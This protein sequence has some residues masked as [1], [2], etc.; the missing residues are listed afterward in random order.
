[1]DAPATQD[2]VAGEPL[3]FRIL[4]LN[5]HKGFT[6]F[7]RRFVLHELREAVRGVGAD[8]VFLQEVIGSHKEHSTRYENWPATSQYE[9]LADTIWTDVAYGRNAV[10]AGGDHGNAL[11][12]KF[13]ILRYRNLDVSQS[14]PERR[15]LL[16][17]VLR[18]PVSGRDIHAIC[19]H[20]GLRESH[21]REQLRLLC[22]LIEGLPADAPLL[23]AGDFNDWRQ[24]AHELLHRGS[25]LREVFVEAFGRAA[26]S[27][28]A[29]MPLL[30]LDRIYVRNVTARQPAVLHELPWSH[31]S[32]HAP[33]TAEITL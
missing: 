15:G 23:V 10:Y 14:G 31:L 26:R 19:V 22:R 3:R 8:V 7:N 18:E 20:L 6:V 1:M 12:S 27:F 25:N 28:P 32:D 4:S 33:L 9:F 29:R 11:L 24:R 16:H 17:C 30:P 2:A 5:T 21:R 13:P